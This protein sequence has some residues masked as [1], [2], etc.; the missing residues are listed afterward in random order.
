V[1]L[2]A[3]LLA[4]C[5]IA[6]CESTPGEKMAKDVRS[7]E[8]ERAVDKLVDRGLAFAQVGDF[9]R[10]E[11]YLAAALDSGADEARVLPQLLRVCIAAKR[12]RVAIDYASPILRKHPND[13]H[14]RFVVASLRATIGDALGARADLEQVARALPEDATVRFAYAVHLRDQCG[15]R[16][17]ADEQ[18]REYLRLAP[19]G[20]H[21]EEARASLLQV[22]P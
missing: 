13:A 3:A 22:V 14:L 16:G 10:A 4:A 12:Y 5:L 9:T 1:R 15:D 8:E 11:Q 21:A 6:G 17:K 20:E 7:V 19:G 2:A 18:F